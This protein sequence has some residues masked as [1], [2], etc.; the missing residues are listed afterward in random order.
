MHPALGGAVLLW[1]AMSGATVEGDLGSATSRKDAVP[2]KRRDP[3]NAV[4]VFGGTGKLG[5]L[6]VKKVCVQLECSG[7]RVGLSVECCQSVHSVQSVLHM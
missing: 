5:R 7:H 4:L 1:R 3:E 6:L 2:P